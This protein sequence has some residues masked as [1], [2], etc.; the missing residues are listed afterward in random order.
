MAAEAMKQP[1]VGQ[2]VGVDGA[3]MVLLGLTVLAAEFPLGALSLLIA[4]AIAAAKSIM[5]ILYFM[6]VRYAHA[7]TRIFVVAGFVWLSVLFTLTM[8][9]YLTR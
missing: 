3:L 7:A 1:S 6:H 4:L 5:V 2:L 8:L 9:E